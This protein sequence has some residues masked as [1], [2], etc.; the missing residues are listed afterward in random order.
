MRGPEVIR[1]R[2]DAVG[3]GFMLNTGPEV[4]FHDFSAAASNKFRSSASVA[5]AFFRRICNA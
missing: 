4:G 5:A 3:V 2:V 1:S